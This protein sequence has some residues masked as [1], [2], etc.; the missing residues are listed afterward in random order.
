MIGQDG[1]GRR[2]H[3]DLIGSAATLAFAVLV[4][5]GLYAAFLQVADLIAAN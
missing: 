5:F 1:R 4:V 2:R 3:R